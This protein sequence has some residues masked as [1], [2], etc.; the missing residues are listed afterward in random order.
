MC[1]AQ[2]GFALFRYRVIVLIYY[3]IQLGFAIETFSKIPRVSPRAFVQ[4][5]AT[6]SARKQGFSPNDAATAPLPASV[7][8][9]FYLLD[10]Y[11]I[12]IYNILQ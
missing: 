3:L 4:C 10:I 5:D 1:Q 11:Y 7:T 6:H 12:W 8:G 9:R 2:F